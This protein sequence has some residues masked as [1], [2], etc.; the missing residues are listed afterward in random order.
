MNWKDASV[1]I[2]NHE[3]STTHGEAVAVLFTIPSTT[4]D[5]GE[6]LSQQHAQ[7]KINSRH[8]L[9]EIITSVRYLCQ[10]GLSL[11]GDKEEKDG[12]LNQLLKMKGEKDDILAN[13]L[14]RKENVYTSPQIQ[15]E[16]IKVRGLSILRSKVAELKKTPFL[17]IMADETTDSSNREQVT[18][19][20]RWVTD[21]LEV[22][23]EFLGLYHVDSIDAATVTMTITELFQRFGLSIGRL[24]AQCYDGASAMSGSRRGD[25]EPKAFFVHCYGHV[26]N[27][28]VCDTLKQCKPLCNALELLMKLLNLLSIHLEGK[29]FFK[30]LMIVYLLSHQA[31]GLVFGFCVQLVGL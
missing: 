11:R 19:F 31:Q 16:M 10:Q 22:H 4:P 26:L 20:L 18:L 21:N 5:I 1:G 15:N 14:K 3:T 7:Q 25:L 6:M 28:S 13:W 30:K 29:Q 12:N 17:A 27:L 9:L 2:R 23:E 24:R 8:A